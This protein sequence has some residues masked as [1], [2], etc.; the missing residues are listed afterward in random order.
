MKLRLSLFLLF[1]ALGSAM[2]CTSTSAGDDDGDDDDSV[3]S[4]SGAPDGSSGQAGSSGRAGSSGTSGS[5]GQA[6]SSG[7][8]L[9]E[10][11]LLYVRSAGDDRDELVARELSTSSERVITDLTGD[12]S[13]GWEIRGYAL[14]P[15][16]RRIA[17]ASLFG[18]TAEDTATG[19]A[20]RAIWTLATDGSDFRRLT[21]TFPNTADGRQNFTIE[22]SEPM[23]TDDGANVLYDFGNY[24]WEG[25]QIRGGSL[26]WSVAASG[27]SLPSSW[28]TPLG[29]SVIYPSRNPTTGEVLLLHSVCVPGSGEEGL[30]LYPKNGGQAPRQLLATG[31]SQG[32]ELYLSTPGWFADGSGFLFAASNADTDWRPGLFVYDLGTQQATRL[33]SP[34]V[35]STVVGAA[36]SPD[37]NRIVYCLRD[38]DDTRDL[39]VI[40]VAAETN[41]PLTTDGKSCV[42]SF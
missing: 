19:L 34:P 23:W 27:A 5:S 40:D 36:V 31:R 20:T 18:P 41:E 24:W 11:T 16:R 2:A 8:A 38:D 17:L 13:S 14:S 9:P 29:C 22:V 6:G 21:P 39:Y 26:P 12:G 33:L 1:A 37:G 28:D 3:A 4:S 7:A 35:G 10:G 42:P 32:I 15:N 25:T 30:Y